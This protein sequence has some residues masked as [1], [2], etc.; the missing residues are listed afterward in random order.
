M[1]VFKGGLSFGLSF[2][3]KGLLSVFQVWFKGILS[4]LRL[5][6]MFYVLCFV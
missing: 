1:A 6:F 3:V 4:W 5:F 2:F